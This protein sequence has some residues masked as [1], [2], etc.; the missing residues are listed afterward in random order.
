MSARF[1]VTGG[2]GFVGSA[3]ALRL[4]AE[5]G[6]AAVTA[7]DNLC[8]RGSEL[9]LPRLTRAGVRFVHGDLR[10]AEDLAAAG[11]AE[12]IL[13]CAALPSVQAGYVGPLRP[14]IDS[15]LIGSIACLEHALSSGAGLLFLST[16]R[17]YPIAAL[18][19]LPLEIR[20]DRLALARGSAGTGWSEHGIAGDFPLAGARSLY[21]ATKLCSEILIDEY[22]AMRG[23]RAISLRCGVIAGPWQQGRV[24]QG[25]V[26]LWAARHRY[27]GRL[28]YLGFG[29]DGRQVRDVLHIDDLCDLVALLMRDATRFTGRDLCA[30]GGPEHSVSLREL[31]ALLALR[32]GR[33][34]E[35]GSRPETH[36]SDIPWFVTD[37]RAITAATGWAPRRGIPQ[38]L[39]DVL[40]WLDAE[41]AQLEPLFAG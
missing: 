30:G 13:D 19:A 9:N 7:F 28:D 18:R 10:N 8:R 20:G 12:W 41:R 34:V 3:L 11:P 6:G 17:V 31:S 2:A 37:N 15:N 26:S 29:G 32:C 1:L 24:D 36:P 22:R 16:S 38:L 33:R 27:G 23:L 35:I 4:A 5:H 14:V 39:D 21:G 40:A 25:F